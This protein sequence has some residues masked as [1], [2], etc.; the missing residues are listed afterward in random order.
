MSGRV[1]SVP[2][3]YLGD[4]PCSTES[5][6]R[7]YTDEILLKTTESVAQGGYG[8]QVQNFEVPYHTLL[9]IILPS[10]AT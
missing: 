3:S 6:D 7:L 1:T 9:K 10:D 5:T 4:P 8:R 2:A